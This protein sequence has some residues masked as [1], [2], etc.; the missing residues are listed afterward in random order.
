MKQVLHSFSTSLREIPANLQCRISGIERRIPRRSGI[1][2]SR[3]TFASRTDRNSLRERCRQ[4]YTAHTIVSRDRSNPIDAANSRK[5]LS[6]DDPSFANLPLVV[7]FVIFR[8]C[9]EFFPRESFQKETLYQ[10]S[11]FYELFYIA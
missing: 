3:E 11:E 1:I 2:N 5:P 9:I 6:A 8:S 4:R 7:E 10:R